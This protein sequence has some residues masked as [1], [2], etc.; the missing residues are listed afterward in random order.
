MRLL[1]SV[2]LGLALVGDVAGQTRGNPNLVL[3][4]YGGVGNGHGLWHTTRQALLYADSLGGQLPRDTVELD[5][6]VSSGIVAGA[7]M[8][9]FPSDRLG[10]SVDVSYRDFGLD[11]TCTPV[12]LAPDTSD[13]TNLRLCNN[14][15]QAATGGSVFGIT[16]GGIVRALTGGTVSPYGRASVTF[17]H[18]SISTL[19][20]AARDE[21][22]S[23]PRSV[24]VDDDP[25]RMSVNPLLAVGL[26][27]RLSPGYQFRFEI[28][29]EL[30]RLEKVDAGA[31]ASGQAPTSIK[32]FHHYALV[33]GLDVV[34]EQKRTRRY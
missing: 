1:S 29:D 2:L 26:T 33:L 3:T 17:A 11:D 22:A 6:R 8:M 9:L 19:A 16:V 34:L 21:P 25:R 31:N 23:S 4:M 27:A 12:Y 20:M 7:T 5:R 13:A 32:L 28:R 10:L 30:A 14:I 18:T 24:V 15:S